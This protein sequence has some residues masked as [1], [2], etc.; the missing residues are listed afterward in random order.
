ML[1]KIAEMIKEFIMMVVCVA[2]FIVPVAIAD[3]V[4]YTYNMNGVISEVDGEDVS[5]V[6]EDGEEWLF[7][8]DG[9]EVGDEVRVKFYNNNTPAD[10]FDDEVEKVKKF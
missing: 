3:E 5:F 9:F 10:R 1:N 7:V 4:Q 2:V 8:G 6:D